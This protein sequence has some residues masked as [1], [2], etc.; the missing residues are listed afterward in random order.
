MKLKPKKS[1]GGDLLR[2][3][4]SKHADSEMSSPIGRSQEFESEGFHSKPTTGKSAEGPSG[5]KRRSV[6]NKGKKN[7][8]FFKHK[9]TGK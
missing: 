3:V 5:A 1:L 9:T 7:F 8:P 6:E 2:T 4:I